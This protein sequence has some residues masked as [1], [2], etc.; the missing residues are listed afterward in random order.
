MCDFAAVALTHPSGSQCISGTD[1]WQRVNTGM[2]VKSPRFALFDLAEDRSYCFRV[3]CCNSAGVSEASVSTEEITVGDKL[4]G[5]VLYYWCTK[6]YNACSYCIVSIGS[7]LAPFQSIFFLLLPF[8][9]SIFS[10]QQICPLPRASQC[11]SGTRTPQWWWLGGLRR[12]SNSWSV[13]ILNAVRW[14][15]T[16]GCLATIN[17]SS[18]PG[19]H[20]TKRSE[21]KHIL[22]NCPGAQ[23]SI[24][25][26]S[27]LQGEYI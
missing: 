27:F 15:L 14:A 1:T 16:C 21:V 6:G 19:M 3:R 12:K 22:N 4:G 7:C 23:A 9:L 8:Y 11:P 25:P 26:L 10:P 13:T 18:R 17:P 24:S 2:P 20:V 5:K